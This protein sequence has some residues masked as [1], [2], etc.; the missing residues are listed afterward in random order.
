MAKTLEELLKQETFSGKD[1]GTL[2]MYS[3]KKD[4]EDAYR[5]NLPELVV[6]QEFFDKAYKSLIGRHEEYEVWRTYNHLE[7]KYFQKQKDFQ[8]YRQ[9][10]FHYYT[11]LELMFE[12]ME[13][14]DSLCKKLKDLN[15]PEEKYN[16]IVS[17]LFYTASLFEERNRSRLSFALDAIFYI[18]ITF[19]YFYCSNKAYKD[20]FERLDVSFMESTLFDVRELEEAILKFNELFERVL[21]NQDAQTTQM[22]FKFYEPIDDFGQFYPREN[23]VFGIKIDDLE[24]QRD[25]DISIVDNIE[26]TI[27]LSIQEIKDINGLNE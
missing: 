18:K 14:M 23:T 19:I 26:N 2:Y 8:T 22:L 27:D 24:F 5:G 20:L 10:F 6:P 7:G 15:L 13:R 17:E 25:V 21:L 1:V 11:G 4:I 9:Q 16:E 3:L 12:E